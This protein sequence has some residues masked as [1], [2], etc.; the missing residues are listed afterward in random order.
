VATF[1]K[2]AGKMRPGK[3]KLGMGEAMQKALVAAIT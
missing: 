1:A 3:E 2:Q